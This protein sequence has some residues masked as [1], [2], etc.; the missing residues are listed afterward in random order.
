MNGKDLLVSHKAEGQFKSSMEFLEKSLFRIAWYKTI[1]TDDAVYLVA[2]YDFSAETH[3]HK[4]HDNQWITEVGD[5]QH[6]RYNA[7]VYQIGNDILVAGG[8]V[9]GE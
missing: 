7:A 2:G 3:I 1:S 9:G 4:F 8:A 6:A 5:L